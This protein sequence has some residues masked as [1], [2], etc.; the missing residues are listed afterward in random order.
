[1]A[2]S[3]PVLEII[4]RC[5]TVY[6]FLFGVLRLLGKKEIGQLRPFDLVLLLIVSE[7]TQSAMVGGDTSLQAGLVAISTLIFADMLVTRLLLK[8]PR[9]QKVLEGSPTVLVSRGQVIQNHMEKE[10]LTEE[11]LLQACR[12]NGVAKIQEVR[13]AVLEVDGTISIVPLKE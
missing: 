5:L 1:M 3:T 9:L 6:V 7:A 10:K 2:D 8:A 4:Y 13:L 12:E 11:D